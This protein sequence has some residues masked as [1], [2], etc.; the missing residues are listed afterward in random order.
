MQFGDR[1]LHQ[2]TGGSD[3]RMQQQSAVLA[4]HAGDAGQIGQGNPFIDMLDVDR[5]GGGQEDSLFLGL[6][7]SQQVEGG[8]DALGF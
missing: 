8:A 4:T 3:A 6:P 2:L 5:E 1:R 7:R